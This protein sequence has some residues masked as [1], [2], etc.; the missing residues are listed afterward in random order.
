MNLPQ[1]TCCV[2]LLA[3]LFQLC[4]SASI[5]KCG[6]NAIIYPTTPCD[7]FCDGMIAPCSYVFDKCGCVGGYVRDNQGN[8]IS[9]GNCPDESR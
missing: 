7:T 8:C 6:P 4:F 2:V 3:V 1:Q 5:N 9:A